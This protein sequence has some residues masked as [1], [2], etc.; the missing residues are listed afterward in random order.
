MA[1]ST[2]N[3]CF[4]YHEDDQLECVRSG[5]FIYVTITHVLCSMRIDTSITLVVLCKSPEQSSST[6]L[7]PEHTAISRLECVFQGERLNVYRTLAPDP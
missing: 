6:T 1:E 5:A 7:L 3:F 4:G 2:R